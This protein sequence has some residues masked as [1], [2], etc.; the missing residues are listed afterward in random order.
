MGLVPIILVSINNRLIP[1][2][3]YTM[4]YFKFTP[5]FICW[6]TLFPQYYFSVL[7]FLIV[8]C[9]FQDREQHHPERDSVVDCYPGFLCPRLPFSWPVPSGNA[10]TLLISSESSPVKSR[11]NI[12]FHLFNT[13][14][15][16]LSIIDTWYNQFA[17]ISKEFILW[18]VL[19]NQ[20]PF[21][22]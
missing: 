8:I 20:V 16:F 17:S 6:S 2:S 15:F 21:I 4:I 9:H 19:G 22:F 18:K 13:T 10:P 12:T 7:Y 14:N 3:I 1:E 11:A 5:R